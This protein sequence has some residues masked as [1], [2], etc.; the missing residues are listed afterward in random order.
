MWW[1]KC[2]GFSVESFLTQ[3]ESGTQCSADG[4]TTP[5]ARVPGTAATFGWSWEIPP[6]RRMCLLLSPC[7]WI[8]G[9]DNNTFVLESVCVYRGDSLTVTDRT[10]QCSTICQKIFRKINRNV[11]VYAVKMLNTNEMN[12]IINSFIITTFTFGCRYEWNM[13]W[14]IKYICVPVIQVFQCIF[15][16]TA[17]ASQEPAPMMHQ[18]SAGRGR[19]MSWLTQK[20]HLFCEIQDVLALS[21]EYI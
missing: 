13:E 7:G 15:R 9:E 19:R 4:P 21:R 18:S 10:G 17:K 2:E 12:T 16:K 3:E 5:A 1:G 14:N 11:Y 6:L 8:S 20:Q